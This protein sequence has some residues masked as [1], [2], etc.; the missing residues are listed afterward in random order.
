M[1]NILV[2]AVL[3][4]YGLF[5]LK[6]IDNHF[7]FKKYYILD[8]RNSGETYISTDYG[9]HWKKAPDYFVPESDEVIRI[10]TSGQRFIKIAGEVSWIKINEKRKVFKKK[11]E[12][13]FLNIIQ[14]NVFPNPATESFSIDLAPEFAGESTITIADMLGATVFETS[15]N[16]GRLEI[17]CS[18]WAKA[19]Y[20]CKII[21]SAGNIFQA[22][23][24]VK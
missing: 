20:L 19:V 13:S 14:V 10:N 17:D 4:F 15:A 3:L 24:L 1:K 7:D 18:A 8:V 22:K 6:A 23:I 11:S 2:L 16:G 9:N 5:N 21:N 12:N